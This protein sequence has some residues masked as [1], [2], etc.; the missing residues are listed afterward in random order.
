M[1]RTSTS[2]HGGSWKIG[3]SS[4]SVSPR[5]RIESGFTIPDF[6]AA[7]SARVGPRYS[8]WSTLTFVTTATCPSTTLVASQVPPTPDLDDGDVDGDV[9]EPHERGRGEDLE[10]ARPVGQVALDAR[11]SGE[12]VGEVVVADRL[13]VPGEA[14]VDPLEVRA[15]VGADRQ[16]RRGQELDRDPH[17]RRL[18]VGAGDVDRRVRQLG[19]TEQRDQGLDPLERRRRAP[20]GGTRRQADGLEVDV[21]VEPVERGS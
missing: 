13:V 12:Q 21:A 7:I 16:A 4:G 5:T 1:S 11:D 17:H 6:S 9:G 8:T 2:T 10:V 15:R 3:V 20:S 14:L 19:R 18:A